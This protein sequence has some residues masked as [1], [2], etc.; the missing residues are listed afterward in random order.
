MFKYNYFTYQVNGKR[1]FQE[2]AVIVKPERNVF[3]LADG[4]GGG[5][6]KDENIAQYACE[7]VIDFIENKMGDTGAT[8]PFEIRKY[9]TLGGNVVFNSMLYANNN[10]LKFNSTRSMNEMGGASVC[11][12]FLNHGRLSIGNLGLCQGFLVRDGQKNSILQPRSYRS[13]LL[14]GHKKFSGEDFPL[15]ALGLYE[16]MQPEI[17]EYQL[18]VDDVLIFMTDGFKSLLSGWMDDYKLNKYNYDELFSGLSLKLKQSESEVDDNST[19]LL[20]KV[21]K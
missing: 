21:S 18:S 17:T 8:L 16:D 10:I 15:S 14:S 20:V 4:F 9:Y 19:I 3:A 5:Q 1:P 2:D 7:S 6:N 11:T 12:G 13:Y